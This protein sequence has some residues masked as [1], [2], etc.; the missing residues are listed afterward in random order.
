M[1][2]RQVIDHFLGLSCLNLPYVNSDTAIGCSQTISVLQL[3]FCDFK[4]ISIP[5]VDHLLNVSLLLLA[6]SAVPT[7]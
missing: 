2:G 3:V 1:G 5:F 4:I 6:S 7:E